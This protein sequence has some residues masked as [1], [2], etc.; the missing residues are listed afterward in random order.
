[1]GSG[2]RSRMLV[3]LVLVVLPSIGVGFFTVSLLDTRLSDRIESDLANARR[4]EAARIN[5][6]LARYVD[7]AASLAAGPH[8]IDFVSGVTKVRAGQSDEPVGGYD[9][10][11][12][13]DPA[14]NEPLAQLTLALQN[15]ALTTGSEV[16][17]L[18][19]VGPDR[20]VYGQTPAFEW[21][22]YD[23]QLVASVLADGQTRFGNA[24][25]AS[26]GDDRL[27]LVAPVIANDEVV[28][29]LV[30]ETRLGPIVDLVVE[31][32]GFG[33]TSEAHIAQPTPQGDAEFITLLRF[34]RDAAFSKVVPAAAGL[35]I[36]ESLSSPTG[37]VIR[38]PDYRAVDSVLAIETIEATGW[39]L[40]VKID[41][42]EAYAP[43]TEV[44][45][46]VTVAGLLTVAGMVVCTAV[47]LN[48]LARRLRTV[49]VAA[50]QI[51]AGRYDSRID[52]RSA[53][54]IGDLAR[55]IDQLAADL[56]TDIRM[57]TLVED[58]LRH[59]A[60]HDGLTGL[61]NRHFATHHLEQL[62]G[63]WSVLF[64]DLD[65]FKTI[66]DTHGHSAGDE[67][68]QAVAE[69]LTNVAPDGATV[70]RWGGD[71]FV[72]VAVDIPDAQQL[73]HEVKR[74]FT[75]PVTT[76]AGEIAVRCS[77]GVASS[78]DGSQSTD[79]VLREADSAMFADKRR[80]GMGRRAWSS[81]ERM[82]ATAIDDGRLEAWLQPILTADLNFG[83]LAGA[84]ALARIRTPDGEV[85]FPGDFLPA[86]TSSD[87]AAEI[88][89]TIAGLAAKSVGSWLRQGLID[90][91]FHLSVNMG[92]ASLRG[93]D[94]VGRLGDRLHAAGLPGP[95]L[96]AEISETASE[97]DLELIRGLTGLGIAIAIDDV[98]ISNS[99]FD[100]L[101]QLRPAFAK[102]DR[103]WLR[104]GDDENIV[105]Q[106]LADV[107][108]ALG[109]P[110]VAEGIETP[111][112]HLVASQ[113]G[114]CR[115]QGFLFGRAVPAAEFAGTWLA[116]AEAKGGDGSLQEAH[117]A[118]LRSA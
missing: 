108:L 92:R 39:G 28:G 97:V 38:S 3:W 51:A 88:D 16:T 80:A 114:C 81:T 72:L 43:A 112:Q 58:R 50:T 61:H 78:T 46:A 100:R 25:R 19:L 7:D 4:L 23:D 30:L 14:A 93:T 85:V 98:G 113:I 83:T 109:L 45:Q 42:A 110:L 67:V 47:L 33:Q 117:R 8:V 96:V 86:I 105:L 37:Q 60:T 64:L 101:L 118:I 44:R 68:L 5:D 12:V 29:A 52:D 106:T 34:E 89:T 49:S 102:I 1:M 90:T 57:R 77:I 27:G 70:A 9:G 40:V 35:P 20:S 59:E 73:A 22:P 10:F 6:A 36:N 66:N 24:F 21:E 15:K 31:H 95:M 99:N 111:A 53:D 115:V 76:S 69:R 48:P 2:V 71:E 13:I 65:D 41:A 107:C 116:Q 26:S 84:E 55:S 18:Q 17:E 32:E 11:D 63:P 87:L 54:E 82:V 104:S 62:S 74:A 79:L 56:D 103:R 91:D 75:A 94:V